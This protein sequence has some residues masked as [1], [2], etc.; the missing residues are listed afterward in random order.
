MQGHAKHGRGADIG[1]VVSG[2]VLVVGIAVTV[3]DVPMAWL[4][5]PLGHGVVLPLAVAY[6]AREGGPGT[7]GRSGIERQS[8]DHL[9]QVKEAYVAGEI[10]EA[11]FERRVEV[12]LEDDA[13]A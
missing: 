4:V 5:W 2:A 12:A 8:N 13:A 10:D 11:E 9:T 7:G 3:A 6:G 1:A